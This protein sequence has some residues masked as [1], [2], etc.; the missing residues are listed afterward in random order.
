MLASLAQ[1]TSSIPGSPQ[2]NFRFF[3]IFA[4]V[5]LL[6]G[7]SNS[8]PLALASGPVFPLNPGHWQPARQDLAAPPPVVDR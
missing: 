2:R 6:G 5:S 3:L 1:Q 8:D 7:C 4:V